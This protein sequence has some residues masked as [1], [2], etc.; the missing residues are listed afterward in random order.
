MY[1][2]H[3]PSRQLIPT[4]ESRARREKPGR[5][6]L[7]LRMRRWAN[8]ILTGIIPRQYRDLLYESLAL[9]VIPLRQYRNVQ[10]AVNRQPGY[11]Q[12]DS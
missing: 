4:Q 10:L 3:V 11:R 12:E 1:I 9:R 6:Q 5:P 8:T 2:Y 7:F